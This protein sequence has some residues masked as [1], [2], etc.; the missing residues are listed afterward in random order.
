M[1]RA[2][3]SV[4]R[5]PGEYWATRWRAPEHNPPEHG[6]RSIRRRPPRSRPGQS[7]DEERRIELVQEGVR[8][9]GADGQP[10]PLISPCEA[11]RTTSRLIAD[12]KK[13]SNAGGREQMKSGE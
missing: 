9:D 12:H 8:R 13:T 5:V 4:L 1:T 6:L 7:D 3:Q 2:A 11:A 10:Q